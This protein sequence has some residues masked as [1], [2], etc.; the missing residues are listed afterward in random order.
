L[1]Q[2]LSD[3]FKQL[4]ATNSGINGCVFDI[5]LETVANDEESGAGM[6]DDLRAFVASTV[7][8][9]P[10][11]LLRDFLDLC[12]D[13]NFWGRGL[14]DFFSLGQGSHPA[15]TVVTEDRGL[16]LGRVFTTCGGRVGTALCNVRV[17][18]RIFVLGGCPMP[19]VL[20]PKKMREQ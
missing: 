18:D 3:C 14:R 9:Q 19:V 16:I 7:N 6:T 15:P 1:K 10:L 2:A 17:G 8:T 13:L 4:G 5:P 11:P 20:R 12:S